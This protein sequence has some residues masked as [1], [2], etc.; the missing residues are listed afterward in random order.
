MAYGSGSIGDGEA[1]EGDEVKARCHHDDEDDDGT[2][3]E[4]GVTGLEYADEEDMIDRSIDRCR[5][6]SGAYSER[7]FGGRF[8]YMK[9]RTVFSLASF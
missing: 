6:R 7:G 3:E 4:G 1:N 2:E 8:K 9:R 5:S